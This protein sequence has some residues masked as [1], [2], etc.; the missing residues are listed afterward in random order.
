MTIDET[1]EKILNKQFNELT[2]SF[3]PQF[4]NQKH[5]DIVTHIQKISET[6]KVLKQKLQQAKGATKL[7]AELSRL[8][9]QAVQLLKNLEQ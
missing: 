1:V 7:T 2:T 6:E 4:G 8:K 5:I 3:R 9:R